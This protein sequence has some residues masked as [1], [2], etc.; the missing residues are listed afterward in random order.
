MT[1][2]DILCKRMGGV[3]ISALL[4]A[5]MVTGFSNLAN[6]AESQLEFVLVAV[7]VAPET[8]GVKPVLIISGNGTFTSGVPD[9]I[10]NS[11]E[12]GHNKGLTCYYTVP[13]G[14]TFYLR[15]FSLS[16][17]GSNKESKLHVET[18]SDGIFWIT[19]REIGLESGGI[20]RGDIVSVPG[21]TA[22]NHFRITGIGAA[23]GTEL[24]IVIDGELVVNA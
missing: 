3:A 14:M 4:I 20:F 22:G 7:D 19:E 5:G 11:G 8:D 16:M 9:T 18:S 10:Y 1:I 6:A 17:V 2:I 12:V 21:I 23:S 13:T 15:A 24:A